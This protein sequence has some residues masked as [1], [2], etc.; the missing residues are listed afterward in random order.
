MLSPGSS[1]TLPAQAPTQNELTSAG[2][3]SRTVRK[4]IAVFNL[5]GESEIVVCLS[6]TNLLLSQEVSLH[7][8]EQFAS[9]LCLFRLPAAQSPPLGIV[10]LVRLLGNI[11]PPPVDRTGTPAY[12][13]QQLV[14][15]RGDEWL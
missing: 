13:S 15:F 6:E 10:P 12:I 1:P 9:S 3:Q 4:S 8:G 11:I 14:S 5:N 7:R 2:V